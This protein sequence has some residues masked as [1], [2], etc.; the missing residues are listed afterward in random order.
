[1]LTNTARVLT[2]AAQSSEIHKP[3]LGSKDSADRRAPPAEGRRVV[4]AVS[5]PVQATAET[6]AV[7]SA[8]RPV[9]SKMAVAM[10]ERHSLRKLGHKAK[11]C[12]C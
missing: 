7:I 5:W 11:F 12:N 6:S 3:Q 1:M 2:C 4:E 8:G 9:T 10:D